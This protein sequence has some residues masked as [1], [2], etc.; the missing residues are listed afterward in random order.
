MELYVEGGVSGSIPF[1]K[2]L[3]GGKLM[4]RLLPDDIVISP[5]LD[6]CFRSALDA[7][8]T[9]QDF[10]Q[11]GIH[12]WLLNLGGD[13]SG[14]GISELMLTVLAAVAQFERT[15]LAERI[16]DAKAELRR[17]CRHQGGTRPFG[18][19]L[20]PP[21]GKGNAPAL[22]PYLAEQAAIVDIVQLRDKGKTLMA[23]KAAMAERGFRM[24][25]QTVA[26][27]IAR[28]CLGAA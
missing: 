16:I 4:R 17:T 6:R 26:N 12:L 3:R 2:R 21:R 14:N 13:C 24:S 20:G 9:I 22:I 7:L 8:Q 15:R 1:A 28:E 19:K 25:H 18:W 5:K 23:I 11:R 27:L 10:K